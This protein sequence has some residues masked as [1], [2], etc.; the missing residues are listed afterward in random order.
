MNC[1]KDVLGASI[2]PF[3]L[4]LGGKG[5]GSFSTFSEIGTN[6]KCQTY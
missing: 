2:A 4:S 1:L 6:L 5:D 3:A